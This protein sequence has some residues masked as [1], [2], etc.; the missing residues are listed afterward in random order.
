MKTDF[1][2]IIF[3]YSKKFI[4]IKT[5][6]FS[7]LIIGIITFLTLLKIDYRSLIYR[8]LSIILVFMIVDVRFSLSFLLSEPFLV[9]S[10][11]CFTYLP[12][13]RS[14]WRKETYKWDEIASFEEYDSLLFSNKIK[15]ILKHP[16]I[17]YGRKCKIVIY[18][19][20]YSRDEIFSVLTERLKYF[21]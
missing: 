7:V 2:E 14:F 11:D 8:T 18:F 10:H 1:E 16:E 20:K 6:I 21:N 13:T 15:I 19:S 4:S 3:K 17:D 12:A 5:I 9:L